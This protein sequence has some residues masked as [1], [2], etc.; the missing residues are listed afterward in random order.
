MTK[1]LRHDVRV[2]HCYAGAYPAAKP[3]GRH[4]V[5]VVALLTLVNARNL[6]RGR[7]GAAPRC[8]PLGLTIGGLAFLVGFGS[9]TLAIAV[10]ALV[11]AMSVQGQLAAG[12]SAAQDIA[13]RHLR[14][15]CVPYPR[16]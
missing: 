4:I 11:G 7:A 16:C 13:A 3:A 6:A 12:F 2:R 5:L 8:R 1:C 9:T 14:S 15:R 10:P